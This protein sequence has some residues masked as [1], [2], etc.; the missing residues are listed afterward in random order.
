MEEL[1]QRLVEIRSEL[2]K[3][4]ITA[5]EVTALEEEVRSIEEQRKAKEV[6]KEKREETLK[7][8]QEMRD[9]NIVEEIKEERKIMENN[10]VL[11]SKEY[12]SA[13]LKNLMGKELNEAEQRAM[14]TTTAKGVPTETGN[15]IVT[16][17]RTISPVINDVDVY[18]GSGYVKLFV[19]STFG[20]ADE[21]AENTALTSQDFVLTEVELSPKRI[22]EYMKISGS[23]NDMSIDD[24]EDKIA[25]DIAGGLAKKIEKK[26][27]AE[28]NTVQANVTGDVTEAN[29]Y[30][31]YG[32]LPT[33][34]AKNAK[35][36]M[37]RATKTKI[38]SISNKSKNDLFL[39]DK[40]LGD[41]IEETDEITTG[42]IIY[43]DAKFIK[44]ELAKNATIE[45][46]RILSDDTHEWLG[47]TMFDT[48]LAIAD[49]FRKL[50]P[51]ASQG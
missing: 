7:K 8:V 45:N 43:G 4:D 47:V 35:F 48:K 38:M 17:L 28:M 49:A 23:L 19:K 22:T 5:E 32:S 6:A 27:Y 18:Y 12:R 33:A 24:F 30:E 29:I 3:E 1:N 36:Y 20:V 37:N 15:K 31:L 21:K 40:I 10:D 13:Y 42:T 25:E 41:L 50:A 11:S 44:A 51:A 46:G 14:S 16:A 2:E 26:I 39:N 34:Y 9:V